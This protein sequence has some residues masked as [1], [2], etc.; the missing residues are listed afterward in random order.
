MVESLPDRTSWTMHMNILDPRITVAALM[1]MFM[2]VSCRKEKA[3]EPIATP[4]TREEEDLGLPAPLDPVSCSPQGTVTDVDGNV[5]PVVQIAGQC[6]MAKDL[7]CTRFKDGRVIPEVGDSEAWGQQEQ[8][9][10]A[11]FGIDHYYNWYA[12]ADGG[13]CP[14]G[15]RVPTDDDWKRLELA[16]GMP[17]VQISK[18][19]TRGMEENVGGKMKAVEEWAHPN[20]GATNESGF[21][22][23]P[24]GFR[25]DAN[26]VFASYLI[27]AYWWSSDEGDTSKAWVRGVGYNNGGVYRNT[28]G[29]RQGMCIRCIKE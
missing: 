19:G 25:Y 26:G 12:V 9:A 1:T 29:K 6:W 15:W 5:Y 20:A 22:A 23:K 2:V 18:R 21:T 4:E 3:E 16:L 28:H 14:E 10:M 13:L 11:P 27:D 8:A 17:D 7:V 24:V